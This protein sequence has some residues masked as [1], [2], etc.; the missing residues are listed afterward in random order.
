MPAVRKALIYFSMASLSR[1]D[2]EQR[3]P[4]GGRSTWEKVNGTVERA[5]RRQRSGM[6]LVE[7]L[8]EV[9]VAGRGTRE[10]REST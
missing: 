4:L 9:K 5:M 10:V 8:P 6:R 1:T 7:D 3:Q 2:R